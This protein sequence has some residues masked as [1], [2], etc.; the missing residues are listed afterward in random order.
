MPQLSAGRV[1][2]VA[3]RIVVE[4]ER[5]RI[6]FVSAGYWSITGTFTAE[7]DDKEFTATLAELEGRRLATGRDFGRDGSLSRADAVILDETGA[8]TLVAELDGVDYTVRSREAKPYR[9]RPAPRS[10]PRPSSRKPDA[11]SV[12]LRRWR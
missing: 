1:Q 11:S 7:G 8:R 2:S 12:C 5:E 9:R 4:R 6:A 10:S 3:T